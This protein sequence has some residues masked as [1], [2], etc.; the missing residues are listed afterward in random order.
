ME[1]GTDE[2]RGA[3]VTLFDFIAIVVLLAS[4]AIGFVRG[5]AREVIT[6]AAFVIAVVIALL[7]LRF[8]GPVA[9]HAVHPAVLANALAILLVFVL[10]YVLL[11]IAGA[12]VARGIQ[13]TEALGTAD[14]TIGVGFGLVRALVLM[15]VFYLA[16]N[17]A[18]PADRVPQWIKS[19]KLYPVAGASG[20]VLMKLEPEGSAMASKVT[21][22]LESAV[23]DGSTGAPPSSGRGSGYDDSSRKGVDELVEKN[24]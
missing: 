21:P 12:Q 10:A 8:S 22:V 13:K 11:R 16:F 24:R 19:A 4:G 7:A 1:Y 2:S 23:K 3:R 20:R 17:A 5:A 15:G 6:V 14:R 9:R 18:T